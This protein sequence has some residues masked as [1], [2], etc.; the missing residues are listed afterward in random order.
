MCASDVDSFIGQTYGYRKGGVGFG[1]TKRRGYDP[2]AR[3]PRWYRRGSEVLHVRLRKEQANTERGV[4]RFAE[5]LIARLKRAG[6]TGEKLFRAGSG[7]WNRK[8][9]AWLESADWLYSI[10][11]R[12]QFLDAWGDQT[13][14]RSRCGS[15]WRATPRT[16]KRRSLSQRAASH[17]SEPL[18]SKKHSLPGGG[19]SD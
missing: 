11:V 9:I 2:A 1:D 13:R 14:S 19:A 5:E 7:F 4:A 8:L 6:A 18:R 15:P 10:S 16:V 12:M 3:E 17:L